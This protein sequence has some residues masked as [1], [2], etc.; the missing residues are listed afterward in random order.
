MS[1]RTNNMKAEYMY[2]EYAYDSSFPIGK[3]RNKYDSMIH[4]DTYMCV[5]IYYVHLVGVC[6]HSYNSSYECISLG[7]K[8][9]FILLHTSIYDKHMYQCRFIVM[10]HVHGSEIGSF[11]LRI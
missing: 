6:L 7:E 2:T 11:R 4:G 3:L 5:Y 8:M 10:Q 1:I 9:V